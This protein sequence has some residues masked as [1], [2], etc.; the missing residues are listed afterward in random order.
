VRQRDLNEALPW[1]HI[2][3]GVSK[4]Y[5]IKEYKKSLE[6]TPTPDCRTTTCHGCG[7]MS[8]A[9]CK[10]IINGSHGN[11]E[12][13]V[14]TDPKREKTQNFYGRSLRKV[15]ETAQPE[16]RLIRLR[17]SKGEEVRF[18]SHLDLVTIFERA[19]R[20]A[21]IKLVYSQGFH[22]H[23]K[24]AYSPPLAIGFTSEAEYLDVQYFQE[25]GKEIITHLNRVLPT[26]LRILKAKNIFSKPRSLASVIN[27]AVYEL[28]LPEI[29]DKA[30]LNE[31]II[32]FIA[33]ESVVVQ[34]QRKNDIV[35][36]DIRPYVEAVNL[37]RASQKLVMTMIFKD[38]K[39]ARVQEVLSEM[40]GMNDEEI[41][42]TRVHRKALLIQVDQKQLTPLD[43]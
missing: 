5:L 30:Q 34:R 17:Y 7:L 27:R 22:P 35:E 28:K 24:I 8:T 20:R 1:D 6:R 41:A 16:A 43:I 31:K 26:G 9:A 18:T 14:A 21:G 36:V 2:D 19:F 29:F 15:S 32:Q 3:K 25:R 10:E 40:F 42:L 13:K 23:P 4:R 38:S 12:P 33:R 11:A 37:D 39:T